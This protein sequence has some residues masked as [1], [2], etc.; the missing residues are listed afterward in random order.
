MGLSRVA[1]L[2]LFTV[3]A[4]GLVLLAYA[5][6]MFVA[7]R[8]LVFPG[9]TRA[10]DRAAASAPTGVTQVWLQPS[11]GRVEAWYFEADSSGPAVV[12]AHGNGELIGD[13]QDAMED[14]R[15][16]GVGALLVEFPGYG[17]SE[18][19]PSRAT[20]RETFV[21]AYDWLVGE[22]GVDPSRIV[23]YGRSVGGG[24][25]ADLAM[26]RPVGAL[27]LQST[28]TSTAALARSML[29]PGFLVRDR[30]DNRRAVESFQ[31]PVLVMHG[32]DDDVIPYRHAEGLAS[33]REDLTVTVIDCA[34]NDCGPAWPDIVANLTAFLGEN[35]LLGSEA[36]QRGSG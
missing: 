25:A 2:G 20:I 29:L 32:V 16:E 19:A 14:L 36:G 23:A 12:F 8:R 6:M 17:F 4:L 28:F 30:F 1:S 34:H 7:Q 18:G 21:E 5:T 31:G 22:G 35:G 24:A 11:F 27:A 10:P 3:K 33:A 15:D 26:D 9:T 13:W